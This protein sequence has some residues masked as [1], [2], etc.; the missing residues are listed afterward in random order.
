MKN[1]A[2]RHWWASKTSAPGD[3]REEE[4]DNPYRFW[5]RQ[6]IAIQGCLNHT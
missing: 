4:I 1:K 5:V 3:M 6:A 2:G